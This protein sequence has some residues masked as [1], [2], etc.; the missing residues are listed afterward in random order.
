MFL[1]LFVMMFVY[2]TRKKRVLRANRER[3]RKPRFTSFTNLT[4]LVRVCKTI[5]NNILKSLTF[6]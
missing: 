2:N 4:W 5:G 1:C 6:V 3:A